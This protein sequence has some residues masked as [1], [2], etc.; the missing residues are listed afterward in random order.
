MNSYDY[1]IDIIAMN[2]RDLAQL[3]SPELTPRSAVNRL[4]R[5]ISI[6]PVLSDELRKAGYR[7][8]SRV[9]SPRQVELIVEHLG[10]P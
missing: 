3:Y 7:K 5:W 9:F 1:D 8:G 4:M 6:H 10:E 2:K